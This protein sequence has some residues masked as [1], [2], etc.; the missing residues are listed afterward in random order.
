MGEG[1]V[2]TLGGGLP[3]GVVRCGLLAAFVWVAAPLALMN[4][5]GWERGKVCRKRRHEC[6]IPSPR[7]SGAQDPGLCGRAGADPHGR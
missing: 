4:V 5:W 7:C 3:K 2:P 1:T 6:C